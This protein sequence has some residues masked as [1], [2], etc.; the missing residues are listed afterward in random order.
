MKCTRCGKENRDIAR[1][2]SARL[3]IN[4][5]IKTQEDAA[6]LREAVLD[7]KIDTIGTDHAPHLLSEKLLPGMKAMSGAPSIQFALPVL[8]TVLP[9]DVVVKKMTS[10][11]RKVFGIDVPEAFAPGMRADFSIVREVEPYAIR[12]CDVLSDRKSVV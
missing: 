1:A 10:G 12:D 11:P 6:A 2:D 5:A 9:I 4:P 3:K 8:L 7:G